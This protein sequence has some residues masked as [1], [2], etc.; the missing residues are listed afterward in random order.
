[1]NGND[2]AEAE[3]T[4]VVGEDG[5]DLEVPDSPDSLNNHVSMQS[6]ANAKNALMQTLNDNYD[7]FS[8]VV[9]YFENEP[10][11][12]Q[13][14]IENGEIVIRVRNDEPG[15]TNP[16]LPA[17]HLDIS[18]IE[19]GE[20]IESI[21]HELGFIIIA[22]SDSYVSFTIVSGGEHPYGGSYSQ[23]LRCNKSNDGGIKIEQWEGGSQGENIHIRDEWY[24]YFRR[25]NH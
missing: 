20:Q 4:D 17:I 8:Q 12:Y 15:L 24:Y 5:S 21:M 9:S 3:Y 11:S 2:D 18:E 14:R 25:G 19:V 16:G 7:I 6:I 22:E 1:M 13:C 10:A 23:G